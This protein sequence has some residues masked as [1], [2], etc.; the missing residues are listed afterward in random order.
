ME[1]QKRGLDLTVTCEHQFEDDDWVITHMTV[2][3]TMIG[4]YLGHPPTG[5]MAST[6]EVE[7]ARIVDGRIVEM[8]SVVDTA[9]ALV[10]L[11]LP[12]PAAD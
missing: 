7:V 6:E 11:G 12:L 9:R 2:T 4:D 3:G 1:S 5:R 10:G 8:W